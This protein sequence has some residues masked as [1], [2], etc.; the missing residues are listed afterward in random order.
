[1]NQKEGVYTATKAVCD[2]HN[3]EVYDGVDKDEQG[4]TSKVHWQEAL[5]SDARKE[6][7]LAVAVALDQGKIDMTEKAKAKYHSVDKLVKEY[8]PGLVSNWL[9]KDLRLNGNHPHEIK[10]KGSRSG[11]GDAIIKN[12]KL[13]Q[14]DPRL[15]DAQR[16]QIDQQIEKR[17][18]EIATKLVPQIDFS[19]LEGLDGFNVAE[20]KESE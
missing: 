14:K 4:R 2:K 5:T 19:V 15:T 11:S 10:N 18:A 16:K 3:I 12:L 1:M 20:F 7:I 8:V 17:K 13:L 9:R 6:I